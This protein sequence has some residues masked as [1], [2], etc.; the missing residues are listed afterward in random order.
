MALTFTPSRPHIM[1]PPFPPYMW[2]HPL[3][4]FP[5]IYGRTPSPLSPL[6][7]VAPPPPFIMSLLVSSFYF[8][9]M[10]EGRYSSQVLFARNLLQFF[11][12][13]VTT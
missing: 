4:P 7:M 10:V 1:A 5:P 11:S 13:E 3:P 12:L 9:V 2:S 6:Y 8:P